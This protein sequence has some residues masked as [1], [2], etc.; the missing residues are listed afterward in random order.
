[1]FAAWEQTIH[2]PTRKRTKTS[3]QMVVTIE[4]IRPDTPEAVE[5]LNEL[6]TYLLQLPYPAESRHAFS[7][8]K[9]LREGV[10]FF[11]LRYEGKPAGC[12]GIKLFGTEYGEVKRMYVRPAFRGLRLGT[13]IL[14]QL[15]AHARANHVDLLRLETGIYQT[16]AI[17]LYDRYGFQRR[18]PFGDYQ[19]DP[20]T[21]YFEKP[22]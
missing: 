19:Q 17:G 1:V 22:L 11:V 5:L 15:T 21:V 13:A 12:G 9:L 3:L 14:D 18:G 10:A 20:N 16:E 8:E 6:D 2:E 7:I 4:A